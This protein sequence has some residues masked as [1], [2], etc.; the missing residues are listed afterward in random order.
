MALETVKDLA[1][2]GKGND[3]PCSLERYKASISALNVAFPVKLATL[4][5]MFTSQ[6]C[7]N[8]KFLKYWETHVCE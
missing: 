8:L 5:E 7:Q 6:T 4:K 1:V 2:Q 3:G